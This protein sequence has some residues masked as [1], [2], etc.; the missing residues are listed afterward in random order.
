MNYKFENLLKI[1]IEEWPIGLELA[2]IQVDS[3][4]P[5]RYLV[6]GLGPLSD[7]ISER[8]IGQEDEVIFR[9]LHQSIMEVLH[10]LATYVVYQ[11]VG[12][13]RAGNIRSRFESHLK[14]A[15]RI[16]EIGYSLTDIELCA[17]YFRDNEI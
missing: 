15:M 9:N 7:S 4:D 12:D 5:T 2:Q 13:L 17:A 3:Q 16:E 14:N 8:W 6:R 11:K 1:A 10:Q